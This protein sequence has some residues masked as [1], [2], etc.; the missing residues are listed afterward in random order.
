MDDHT[1]ER[2]CVSRGGAVA[3]GQILSSQLPLLALR[4]LPASGFRIRVFSRGKSS[5][6]LKPLEIRRTERRAHFVV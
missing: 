1:E 2:I 3:G 4:A 5:R 6:M